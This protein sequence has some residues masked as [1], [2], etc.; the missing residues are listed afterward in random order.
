VYEASQLVLLNYRARAA[1]F[2]SALGQKA[3]YTPQELMSAL[4]LKADIGAAQINVCYG[5]TEDIVAARRE[6]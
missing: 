2:V 1:T 5:P 6:N 4:L 3:T